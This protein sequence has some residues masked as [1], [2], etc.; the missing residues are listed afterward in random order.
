MR[1]TSVVTKQFVF[2]RSNFARS[3]DVTE[4]YTQ[5]IVAMLLSTQR[6]PYPMRWPRDTLPSHDRLF[7]ASNAGLVRHKYGGVF[8]V[9]PSQTLL[10]IN[11]TFPQTNAI[12]YPVTPLKDMAMRNARTEKN[13]KYKISVTDRGN[14]MKF[15]I[16]HFW[17]NHSA[18][19]YIFYRLLD[20]TF[21]CFE[22]K[23]ASF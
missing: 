5:K 15:R 3:K 1:E 10:E 8:F 21:L 18:E 9:K 17:A 19:R 12:Y 6:F 13:L 16:F 14:E 20:K 23:L 7:A 2:S 11:I 4:K 22:G